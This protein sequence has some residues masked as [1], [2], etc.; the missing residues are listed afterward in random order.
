M[1]F[2]VRGIQSEPSNLRRSLNRTDLNQEDEALFQFLEETITILENYKSNLNDKFGKNDK[3]NAKTQIDGLVPIANG[4]GFSGIY[5][6]TTANVAN[7]TG[8]EW[9]VFHYYRLGDIVTVNG[10]IRFNTVTAVGVDTKVAF[11]LPILSYFDFEF[12]CAGVGYSDEVNQGAAIRGDVINQRAEL[13][14]LSA[15]NGAFT[16]YFTFAY[17]IIAQ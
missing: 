17:R 7:V 15:V 1:A 5:N 4:G 2:K 8:L 13:R 3:I 11:S 16:M 12:Q 10:K 9:D 6:P 14:F